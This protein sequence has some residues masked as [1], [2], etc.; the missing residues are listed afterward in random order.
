MLA[1]V[2][3]FSTDD[4]LSLAVDHFISEIV[5]ISSQDTLCVNACVVCWNGK[6]LLESRMRATLPRASSISGG[7]ITSTIAVN[8]AARGNARDRQKENAHSP[9]SRQP[10]TD[11]DSEKQSRPMPKQEYSSSRDY[12]TIR[13]PAQFDITSC[14][15]ATSKPD[16]DPN[17]NNAK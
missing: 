5:N 17:R 2:P 14:A 4:Q 7:A 13:D 9:R 12:T 10:R 16:C 3:N 8:R 1:R 11:R 6:K 15:M